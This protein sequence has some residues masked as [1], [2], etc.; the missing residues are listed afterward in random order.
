VLRPQT[1]KRAPRHLPLTRDAGFARDVMELALD[2][3][4]NHE[5]PRLAPGAHAKVRQISS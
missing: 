5:V 2:R 3:I 1:L 4:L